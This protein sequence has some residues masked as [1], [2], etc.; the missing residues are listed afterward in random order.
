MLKN[1]LFHPIIIEWFDVTF[2]K[3]SPPQ[4]K[5]WPEITRGNNTLIFAPIGSGKTLAVFKW[6]IKLVRQIF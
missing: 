2:K 3:P 1:V 6:F 4:T 5:G